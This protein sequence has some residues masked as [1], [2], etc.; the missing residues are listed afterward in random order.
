MPRAFAFFSG[1]VLLLAVTPVLAAPPS[2]RPEL[3][4]C[5]RSVSLLACQDDYGNSYSVAMA[6]TTLFMRGYEASSHR[7][8]AQTNSRYGQLTFFTGVASDGEVWAGWVRKVGWTSV[9]RISSSSGI[10][11]KVICDRLTGCR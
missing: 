5:T 9:T 4:L 11:S 7:R 6:G 1:W 8:W 10:H 2:I 3:A